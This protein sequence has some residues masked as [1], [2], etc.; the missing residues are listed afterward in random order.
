MRFQNAL[1]GFGVLTLAAAIAGPAAAERLTP[2]PVVD[3]DWLA[4]HH[5][6]VRILDVRRDTATFEDGHIPGA[7]L[8]AWDEVR[9]DRDIEG[10]EFQMILPE[11]E[12]FES[13]MRDA[14]I[15]NDDTIVIISPG[16]G[17]P[18][19]TIAARV[20]WQLMY[21]GHEDMAILDGG[22]LG[23]EEAGHELD[24]G[25]VSPES[26]DF[27]VTAQ[28]DEIL[29]DEELLHAAIDDPDIQHIDNRPQH[30]YLGLAQ[31]DYVYALGHIPEAINIPFTLN[32]P[33][34]G[35]AHL[36]DRDQLMAAYETLGMNPESETLIAY[37]NSGHVS[38]LTWFVM[39]EVMGLKQ[40]R[41]Y[42]G[43]MHA[44]T[45]DED[46]PVT[47]PLTH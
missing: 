32:V 38:A 46:R 44:W 4:E 3:A 19:L 34:Q 11:P 47:N 10:V 23:W 31:E 2:G 8:L 27:S 5:E 42:D 45:L 18:D 40:A 37:C 16:E 30:F 41:L 21:F 12:I 13:L 20:Y 22:T 14:G 25:A 39:S 17:A 6:E 1:T 7:A 43:S 15:G 24:T 35:A 36:Y 26:G 29:A 33:M 28:N 9:A